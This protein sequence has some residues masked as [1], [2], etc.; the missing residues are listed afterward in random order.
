M[1]C[2]KGIFVNWGNIPNME[3]DFGP[4]NLF[5]GG[6]GSGKTTAADGLQSLMTAAY[7]NLY[8]YNPGQDETTQ[9]GRGGK[10]VRT[11]ASYVLGCDDGSYARPKVTD[12]YVAGVFYPTQGEAGEVFTAVMCVRAS[13]D[14]AGNV[15]QARQ[16][17]LLFLI[18]PNEALSLSHF[19][20]EDKG[21]KYVAPLDRLVSL[22]KKEY[23]KNA[24][25]VYEK[26]GPYLRRL[27]AALRGQNSAVSDREAKHAAKTFSNFMAYKPVKSINQFVANE[28]LEPNDLDE[29]IKQVSELMKTI[30]G[31]E[32]E[33][34]LVKTALERLEGAQVFATKYISSWTDHCVA[35][36]SEQTRQLLNKQ[37]EYLAAKSDQSQLNNKVSEVENKITSNVAS[38]RLLHDQLVDLKAK[39]Q[40]ISALKDKDQLDVE[41]NDC[42]DEMVK[43]AKPLLEQ[44]HQFSENVKHTKRLI[45]QLNEHSIAV[46]LPDLDKKDFRSKLNKVIEAGEDTGVDTQKLLNADW[47]G[48]ADVE[49]KLDNL[50][51]LEGLH[52]GLFGVLHDH[53]LIDLKGMSIRDRLITLRSQKR[54][55]QDSVHRQISTKENEIKRLKDKKVSYPPYVELA[56]SAINAQCPEAKPCVLCDYIEIKSPE[57]QMAIEGYMGG[58]RFSIIVDP[59]YEADAIRIVRGMKG[60]KNSAK[61]I[62]GGKAKASASK[63]TVPQNS[64]FNEMTF[65]HKIVEYYIKASYGYVLCVE[66]ANALK[67]TSR[68]LTQDGMGSGSY[69]MFRCDIEDANLVFG[70]GARERALIA[71]E[72]E[73]ESLISE[74]HH[75]E[76]SFRYVAEIAEVVELIKPV[77]C[78]DIVQKMLSIFRQLQ[79]AENQ[80]KN[81]DLSDFEALESELSKTQEEYSA[82]DF[83]GNNLSKLLGELNNSSKQQQKSL[84]KISEEQEGIQEKQEVCEES[85]VKIPDLYSLFDKEQS[86]KDAE[87]K[88]KLAGKNFTLDDEIHQLNEDMQK[89]E[90]SLHEVI[91]EHNQSSSSHSSINYFTGTGERNGQ[92]FFKAIVGIKDGIDLVYNS[93]KNNILVDKHEKLTSLKDSFNTAFVTNLCHSIYQSVN[94]G[95]RMLDELNNELEHH[96]FGADKERFYFETSW[97]PEFYDYYKFFKEIINVP[98]LGD[99]STLFDAELSEHAC[100][101]RDKL[102]EMLLNED[103]LVATRELKRLSDYRN[104]RE[105]EI[106]KE[107]EGKDPIALSKYGTGSGGQLETPAYIIRS[108]AVTSAF[109]FNEGHTHC[110]MVLV[111]EAFSKMDETRSREVINYLT[112]TLGLQLIFIM[113]TSKSGQYLNSISH[114]VVFSKYPVTEKVGELNTRVNVNRIECNQ[115]KIKDLWAN[116]KKTVRHQ[117]SMDFMEEFIEV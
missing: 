73:L 111:D 115:E 78:S 85:I 114:H 48:I 108:A 39:R 25:E 9:R 102:L 51:H 38:K 74:R 1:F 30:H 26:K 69:S 42:R 76:Q 20:R 31:M 89:S 14:T 117:A 2:K 110:R 35:Q 88:A 103:E 43:Q 37:Q 86:L 95:K 75:V 105:Y 60:R 77:H 82:A 15:K 40:G 99:G 34:R 19:V 3:F 68:G 12:G 55:E 33:T 41:V 27:Y 97:V 87:E 80:L 106:Y 11:L 28:I 57:W 6:N 62:Q 79:K 100:K 36:Y 91:L 112:E 5:S 93:F 49:N 92:D 4:V 109:K 72:R 113:P 45:Q 17:D 50:F 59:D 61:V 47:V 53:H 22:L 83:E 44:N 63:M 65:Q 71:K 16:E 101:M 96:R 13:L 24:I 18:I 67:N 8:N 90:R 10:Q 94:D 21:G 58:N 54:A 64:I 32:E 84:E 98:N 23:G 70:Q 52:R 7:E 56:V 46:D 107:P 116:H 66:D 104:Y 29:G 81:L